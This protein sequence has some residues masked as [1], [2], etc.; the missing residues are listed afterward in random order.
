MPEIFIFWIYY[1]VAILP[2]SYMFS[3]FLLRDFRLSLFEKIALGYAPTIVFTSIGYFCLE[4]IGLSELVVGLSIAGMIWLIRKSKTQNLEKQ[5]TSR[6]SSLASCLGISIVYIVASIYLFTHFT[7]STIAPSHGLGGNVYEDTLWTVGNTWSILKNGFPAQDLRF[8]D[9]PLG[10]HIGQNIYY[11][12]ISKITTISPVILHLRIA[13]FFDLF[14]LCAALAASSRVF[15]GSREKSN[16]VL[17]IPVLFSAMEITSFKAGGPASYHEIYTNPISLTFGFSSFLVLLIILS[18]N[19]SWSKSQDNIPSIYVLVLFTLA[20]STKGILGVL[21]PG[22]IA[23]CVI[24]RWLI[25]KTRF[26]K[27]DVIL[28]LC[29]SAI[30]LT[31]RLT[32]FAGSGGWI[33]PPQIEVSPVAMQIGEKLGLEVAIS[34]SYYLI[35]PISRATR[36]LFH[37]ALWN[38][39]SLALI[40]G[41]VISYIVIGKHINGLKFVFLGI[42]ISFIGICGI[43]YGLN[44]MENYWANLYYYKYSLSIIALQLGILGTSFIEIIF[45]KKKLIKANTRYLAGLGLAFVYL[46]SIIGLTEKSRHAVNQSSK[47]I[48]NTQSPQKNKYTEDNFLNN[49]EYEGL[50]WIQKNIPDNSIIATDRKNKSGKDGEYVLSVWFNYSAYTGLQFYNEGDEYNQYQV[51]KVSPQRWAIVQKLLN[52]SDDEAVEKAWSLVNADYLLLT[53]RF[54]NDAVFRRSLGEVVFE[55]RGIQLIKNPQR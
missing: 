31:L 5:F 46:P 33:V 23:L 48:Q 29:M 34:N 44:I 16:W 42:G 55:N 51:R 12:F 24:T 10:Y 6:R 37:V 13:P 43:L 8:V 11:A 17:L 15:L 25:R 20:V 18:R 19:Y 47:L 53:K 30:V 9:V 40:G 38:W 35:G 28:L 41:V 3:T 27:S 14:F 1:L 4:S 26:R 21:I 50:M 2:L 39:S 54:S 7:V 32:I 45:Q 22:S 49:E 36:F 52:A